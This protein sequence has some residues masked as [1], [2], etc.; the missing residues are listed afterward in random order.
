MDRPAIYVNHILTADKVG[1]YGL[2]DEPKEIA[3]C[4]KLAFQME[5]AKKLKIFANTYKNGASKCSHIWH[6]IIFAHLDDNLTTGTIL[7]FDCK[8]DMDLAFEACDIINTYDN[9]KSYK[10]DFLENFLL[11]KE[12]YDEEMDGIAVLA[13]A[14]SL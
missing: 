10:Q 13:I 7:Y 8:N 12:K 2:A 11:V 5:D 3:N 6:F 9:S 4:I 14:E 1:I